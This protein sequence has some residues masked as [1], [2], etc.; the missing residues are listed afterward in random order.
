MS[1]SDLLLKQRLSS[2]RSA[3]GNSLQ[4]EIARIEHLWHQCLSAQVPV[5]LLSELIHQLENMIKSGL[6]FDYVELAKAL[7]NLELLVNAIKSEAHVI[8]AEH[9]NQWDLL[10]SI[11]KQLT[12]SYYTEDVIADT[13]GLH[14]F[15]QSLRVDGSKYFYCIDLNPDLSAD[16]KPELEKYGFQMYLLPDINHV[17]GNLEIEPD[18][19]MVD[20]DNLFERKQNFN[21]LHQY[22]NRYQSG[23][24]KIGLSVRDDVSTRLSAIQSGINQYMIKPVSAHTIAEMVMELSTGMP[25]RGYRVLI[26]EQDKVLARFYSTI[27][28]QADISVTV[29]NSPYSL[30]Q[31]I[32]EVR[33]ELL[34]LGE[35]VSG[36]NGIDLAIMLRQDKNYSAISILLLIASSPVNQDEYLLQ[37]GLDDILVKPLNPAQLVNNV[38]ARASRVRSLASV[39]VNMLTTLR[40]LQNQQRAMDQHFAVCVIN[41]DNEIIYI[42]DKFEA[43]T[44]YSQ[45]ELLGRHHRVLFFEPINGKH[46]EQIYAALWSNQLWS[47]ELCGKRKNGSPYWSFLTFVPFHD[48]QQR[49]YQYVAIFSDVTTR[50][51]VEKELQMTR[52]HAVKADRAKSDFLTN[53]SHELR[54]PMNAVLGFAQLAKEGRYSDLGQYIQSHNEIYKAGQHLLQLINDILDLTRVEQNELSIDIISVPLKDM[55]NECCSL[56]TPLA[57]AKDIRIIKNYT[58]ETDVIVLADPLRLKQIFVNLLSNAIKYNTNGGTVSLAWEWHAQDKLRVNI[59]DSGMGIPNEQIQNL[60]KPFGRLETHKGQEGV[61][62]GLVLSKQLAKLMNGDIYVTSKLNEGTTFVVTIDADTHINAETLHNTKIE[63]THADAAHLSAVEYSILYIEDNYTNYRVMKAILSLRPNYKL[64]HVDN[65]EAGLKLI[66]DN[67]PDLVMM[68]I[69]LP[70]MNGILAFY[71]IRKQYTAEQLPVVAVTA[72]ADWEFREKIL[73]VSFDDY[74][75]KPV[76]VDSFLSTLDKLILVSDTLNN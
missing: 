5:Q 9:R 42:N 33:P 58:H 62:I 14:L 76:I 2:L 49:P 21:N 16:L 61:G 30:I 22:L 29:I 51:L 68:D 41:L 65:A 72:Y 1:D 39:N 27:L 69:Q 64:I 19:V 63:I 73:E 18:I 48:E 12:A 50:V 32:N 56:V 70:G 7:Q 4:Q 37:Y 66:S 59:A 40:D 53:M 31:S 10:F 6:V 74:I 25:D 67:K 13:S 15:R 60:F 23:T 26:L 11:L 75:T 24:L 3:Y 34:L 17:V 43:M 46:L 44:G 57:D 28:E 71:E 8:Q 52:D 54:T 20:L 35:E 45:Q 55:L 36:L 47:G 38:K